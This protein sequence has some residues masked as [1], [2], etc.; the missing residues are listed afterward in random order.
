MAKGYVF[1]GQK[2]KLPRFSKFEFAA[3]MRYQLR[4]CK[5]C[6]GLEKSKHNF[7]AM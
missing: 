4:S 6:K 3:K 5:A 1:Y 7:S 2:I